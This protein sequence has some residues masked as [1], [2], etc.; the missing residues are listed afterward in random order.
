MPGNSVEKKAPACLELINVGKS[1]G[2]LRAIDNVSLTVQQGERLAII[3]PN[4][5]GKT[6]LFN[7]I[8]GEFYP[9]DGKVLLYGKD[10]TNLPNYLRVAEGL[11]RTY[12]ITTLFWDQSILE[13]LLLA[14]SGTRRNK[15][16]M[17]KSLR[18]YHDLISEAN[19][20]LQQVNLLEKKDTIIKN[21]F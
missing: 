7:M 15:F 1:F 18:N 20:L 6:T 12:Q 17:W 21:L 9:T 8:S 13:N 2:G 5:A 4:G 19:L 14:L 3:G 11:A 16:S 10:V